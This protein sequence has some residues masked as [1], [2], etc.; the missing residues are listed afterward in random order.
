MTG[1]AVLALYDIR[2][3]LLPDR[4][5][6]PLIGLSSMMVGLIALAYKD[7]A[8]VW[9]AI[10]GMGIVF[11]LFYLLFQFS[12]GKWIGGGD[13][14]L[15]V[16]LGLLAGG[17]MESLLLLFIASVL[18]TLYGVSLATVGGQKLNRTLRIPFGPFLL[19]ATVV[20]VLFGAGIINWYSDLVL[21]I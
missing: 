20:V 12:K 17:V 8:V 21:S 1:F 4:V 13:V 19:V 7:V 10:I 14:K 6:F 18:G 16:A 3:Y 9:E 5:V 15:G 11:G 2:W